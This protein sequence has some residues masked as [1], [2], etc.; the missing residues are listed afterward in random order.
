MLQRKGAQNSSGAQNF[1]PLAPDLA[2]GTAQALWFFKAGKPATSGG[3]TCGREHTGHVRFMKRHWPP[4]RRQKR[5]NL[6]HSV[7]SCPSEG[8]VKGPRTGPRLHRL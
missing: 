6:I 3:H 8:T 7:N 2:R 4:I 5:E 1:C